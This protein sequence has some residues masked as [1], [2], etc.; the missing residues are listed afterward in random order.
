[1]SNFNNW[2]NTFIDEKDVPLAIWE[3]EATDGTVHMIDSDVVIEAIKGAPA[4]EQNGIKAVIVKID[5]MNGNVNDYF[6]HL[7]QALVNNY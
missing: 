4:H 6:R 2:F 3:I 1:M 5:F 7:A